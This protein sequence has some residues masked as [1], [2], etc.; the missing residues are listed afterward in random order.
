MARP[1]VGE[2]GSRAR[3]CS[4]VRS[5][6]FCNTRRARTMRDEITITTRQ[7]I[8]LIIIISTTDRQSRTLRGDESSFTFNRGVES[9]SV[10]WS[11]HHEPTTVAASERHSCLWLLRIGSMRRH[12]I[13]RPHSR[14][15]GEPWY[16]WRRCCCISG[17]HEARGLDT[18]HTSCGPS[19]MIIPLS[20]L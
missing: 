6:N 10:P 5:E 18:V 13:H 11:V 2:A 12:T 15:T 7:D 8:L 4:S 9:V 1:D 19:K 3:L 17:G 14:S 16:V 20:Q